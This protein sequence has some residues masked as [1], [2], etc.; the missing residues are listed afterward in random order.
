MSDADIVD[1]MLSAEDPLIRILGE[2]LVLQRNKAADYNA[3][4]VKRDDYWAFGLKSFVQMLWTKVLRL[5]SLVIDDRAPKNE[6]IEDTAK[7]LIVYS[8]FM[9][10]WMRRR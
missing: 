1:A 3:S 2:V 4:S 10:E 8:L 6:S 9:I 7:D 5:R